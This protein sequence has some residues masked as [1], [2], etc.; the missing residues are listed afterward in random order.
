MTTI[1]LLR[2]NLFSPLVLAFA[3]GIFARLV[4]SELSLP[5]DLYTSLSIYLLFAL[6]LK[7]GVELSETSFHAIAL[8]GLGT[9]AL[10]ILT[11]ISAFLVARYLGGFG[12]VDS[13]AIAA[14]YGS[15][16]AVTFIAAT[17]FASRVGAEPEGFMPTLLTLLESPG[18][19][20]GLAIGA[21]FR[22]RSKLYKA[23][24]PSRSI[25]HEILT[26][27]SMI[28]LVG[29]LL[30]GFLIGVKSYEPVKPFFEG[31]FKGALVLFLLEMGLV[32][33]ERIGDLRRAGIR[34]V[35]IGIL[36]PILHGTLGVLV[37]AMAGLSLGGQVV[38]GSMAASASY[39]AAPPAVRLTLPEANPTYFLTASLAITFPFNLV[40]GIP[41]YYAIANL[42]S[43]WR[44]WT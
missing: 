7:G 41:L 2:T 17:Q 8:P 1:D 38:L 28:L 39:I 30:I 44:G 43:S 37:G 3:L 24:H 42:I 14:H 20:V 25:A 6:G 9:I 15:V 13:A 11:P 18:I 33:G 5:R 29:G 40:I 32:A 16:S 34:L 35:A 10:G 36:L 19:H 26:A 12:Q 31:G 27:R 21:F 22:S 23:L 4:R